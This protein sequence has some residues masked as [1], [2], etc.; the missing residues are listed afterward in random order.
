MGN[1]NGGIE[2]NCVLLEESL[3]C[4]VLVYC[5][6]RVGVKKRATFAS[7]YTLNLSFRVSTRGST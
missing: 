7:W 3:H 5:I 2:I 1:M 4:T 6:R